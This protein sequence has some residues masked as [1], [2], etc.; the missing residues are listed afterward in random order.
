ML[1]SHAWAAN[2]VPGEVIVK[3]KNSTSTNSKHQFIGK[4]SL[5]YKMSLKKSWSRFNLHQFKLKPGQSVEA[6]IDDMMSDPNV[7]Y[8]EPNYIFDKQSVG[9][10][11]EPLS[12]QE[13]QEAHIEKFSG[14]SQSFGL[15]TADISV[16]QAWSAMG[17]TPA[18]GSEP[19]VAVIDSGVDYTHYVFVDTNAIWSNDDE[20]ADNGI[21]DDGNGYIDDVRGW[22]FVD[23]SNDPMD[24][25]N[26]GTHVAGIVLG[27]T[28]DILN[29]VLVPA[30]VKIMPLKF[31]NAQGQGS[32]SDAIEAINYAINNG[33]TILNNSWGGGSFSQAL[34]DA[35][36]TSYNSDVT[37]VAAAGN[38][39]NNNDISATYPASYTVPNVLSIAATDSGDDLAYFSNFG[40]QSV[41]VGS[42][43]VTILSTLPNGTFG[44]S[45]GTSMA[46]PFVA[47]M[48][49][50]MEYEAG[51]IN[52]FQ[53]REIIFNNSLGVSSLTNKVASQARIDAFQA[54]SYVQ[55]N[56]VDSYKPDYNDAFRGPASSSSA[57]SA[58]GCGLVKAIWDQTKGG[59]NQSP[60]WGT[61]ALILGLLFAP[62]LVLLSMRIRQ[63]LDPVNRRQH[64]RY[65]ID[66]QVTISVG[67]REIVGN[68]SSI[69]LG[70]ARVDTDA[71]LENGGIVTM[72]IASPDGQQ[73]VEV[74]GQVVWSE[75]KKA[76][77]VQFR[78]AEETALSAIGHWT[79][80]LVKI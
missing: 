61:S 16:D 70:G 68:V 64:P 2:Y 17:A 63:Q 39:Q 45:Q 14:G 46:A 49:A 58:G 42:P 10:E 6:A 23:N 65:K 22:N 44:Y 78:D 77:G 32:T 1:F 79:K 51:Q 60:P 55:S 26:H 36:I 30:K 71:M 9:L 31:L 7:E 8:A 12:A 35:V 56:S 59:N 37:F 47:G 76:Y 80:K 75:E 66:S 34:Q 74:Q 40:A 53:M 48:A 62:M 73:Q 43:G 52:G 28:Q 27:T 50:L 5:Q 4:A 20:I 57:S 24:D 41:H 18:S 33:A 67:G 11:G 21:D 19:V 15:T 38:S 72:S 13:V 29:P 69:S 25:D 54:V 3:V